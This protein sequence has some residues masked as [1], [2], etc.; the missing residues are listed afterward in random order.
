[1]FDDR[2]GAILRAVR[3]RRGLR[4]VDVARLARVSDNTVSRVERGQFDALSLRSIRAVARAVEVRIDLALWS[5][6]GDLLHFATSEHAG[7]VESIIEEL[8]GLGW[9][10][11]AEVSFS[12]A[13]ERGFIDILAW[14]AASRTL[15]VIEVKTEVVDVGELLGTFDRKRRLARGIAL[16]LDWIP[17]SVASAVIVL[18]TH[19]NRRRVDDHAETIRTQLP[20]DGRR[21]RG[22]LRKPGGAVSALAFWPNR[23][24]GTASQNRRGTRRV[25]RVSSCSTRC[26]A[27]APTVARA[28]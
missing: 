22:F 14:H 18:D 4:Q 10:A 25:R 15:L 19:T 21:L 2:V 27:A 3:V 20:A 23:H 11:R 17:E 28:G 9:D 6:H 7:L 1:M 5:R 8:Q 13:G 26:S 24:A 12:T 16:E